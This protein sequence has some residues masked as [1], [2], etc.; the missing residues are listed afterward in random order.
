VSTSLYCHPAFSDS[1]KRQLSTSDV[2]PNVQSPWSQVEN[3]AEGFHIEGDVILPRADKQDPPSAHD[4]S[5]KDD[6]S[7]T[8][9]LFPDVV[10]DDEYVNS[11]Q[12]SGESGEWESNE[13]DEDEEFDESA[14][15]KD[16]NDIVEE[17]SRE[18]EVDEVHLLDK[19]RP[20][21]ACGPFVCP[22]VASC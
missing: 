6:I 19:L 3:H 11:D 2:L 5:V 17:N 22:Q 9:F 4:L 7:A 1:C 20:S 14:G 13:S 15:V 16:S 10:S 21:H 8:E 12:E 18:Q